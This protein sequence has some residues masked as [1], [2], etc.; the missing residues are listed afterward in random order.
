MKRF[1]IPLALVLTSAMLVV[2]CAFWR[3]AVKTTNELARILC[4]EYVAGEDVGMS[5]KDWCEVHDNLAPFINAV[6]G[7]QEETGLAKD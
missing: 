7:L 2:A 3:P 4:E 5:A 1:T 6:V